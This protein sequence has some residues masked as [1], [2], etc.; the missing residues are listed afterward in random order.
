MNIKYPAGRLTFM[1]SQD[2]ASVQI[3][4]T[5]EVTLTLEVSE[6]SEG[7]NVLEVME[8]LRNRR[9][10]RH[11]RCQSHKGQM[12]HERAEVTALLGRFSGDVE[13]IDEG[14]SGEIDVRYM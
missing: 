14:L 1:S 11:E 9:F 3:S 8:S 4:D 12:N 13:Q 5:S 10:W 2:K 6:T 7:V